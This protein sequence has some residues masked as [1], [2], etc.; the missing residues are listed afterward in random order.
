M[1]IGTKNPSIPGCGFHHISIQVKG[2]AESLRCYRDV[3]GMTL[4]LEFKIGE[5]HF[6]L[7]DMGDGSYVEL[8][9]AAQPASLAPGGVLAHFALATSDVKAAV[10]RIRAAGYRI[11]V[12]PKPVTLNTLPAWVAFFEGPSGESVE[13]FQE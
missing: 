5:R 7:L 12:E 11:T 6:A 13:L 9:E 10:E 2:Y 3:L 4:R 1:P 8:Q